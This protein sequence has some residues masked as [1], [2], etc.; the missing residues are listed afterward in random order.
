MLFKRESTAE[1]DSIGITCVITKSL[2]QRK[3]D[4]SLSSNRLEMPSQDVYKAL[5]RS[6]RTTRSLFLYR[7]LQPYVSSL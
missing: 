1:C 2:D 6:L 4:R 3:S 7:G 5:K